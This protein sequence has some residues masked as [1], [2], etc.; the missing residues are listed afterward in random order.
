MI[1]AK[2]TGQNVSV[3]E[4]RIRLAKEFVGDVV[5]PAINIAS[6]AGKSE[7]TINTECIGVV[8]EII[9]MIL[10]AGFCVECGGNDP[11]IRVFW[12]ES[13]AAAILH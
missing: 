4:S 9:N 1:S 12:S 6:A 11:T 8:Y 5:D 13:K 10:D 7:V 3:D 2:Q